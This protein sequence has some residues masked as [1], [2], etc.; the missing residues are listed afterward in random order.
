MYEGSIEKLDKEL[1]PV[2]EIDSLREIYPSILHDWKVK[3]I[4]RTETEARI[5]VLNEVHHPD[6]H[7]NTGSR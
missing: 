4:F 2:S 5:S 6:P 7:P 1:L 3:P